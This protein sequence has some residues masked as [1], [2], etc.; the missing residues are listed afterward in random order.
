MTGRDAIYYQATT[1]NGLAQRLAQRLAQAARRDI[2]RR[3]M[4][5]VAPKPGEPVLDIG[6]SDVI[7]AIA[8][9]LETLHPHPEDITCASLSDGVAIRAAYPKVKHVTL[10]G[11]G[12]LPFPDDSF[13]AV[14]CNAV[15]EHVGDDAARRRLIG[16]A[17]RVA[18]KV[19][20]AIPHRWFPVEHHSG[21][22]LLHYAPRL[23]RAVMRWRGQSHWANPG[24]LEFLDEGRLRACWPD[25]G[26]LEIVR[27]GVLTGTPLASNLVAVGRR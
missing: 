7:D 8:N 1:G 25:V 20:F 9:P 24:E 13:A 12:S 2:Y 10:A 16:Q 11:D 27:A 23:F 6:A 17:L 19:C 26:T 4:T 18:P 5:M 15:L 22:P 3:F 14:F 21:T